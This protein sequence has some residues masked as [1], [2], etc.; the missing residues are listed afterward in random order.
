MLLFA[1]YQ[2]P[3]LKLLCS[4]FMRLYFRSYTIPQLRCIL[5]LE[6]SCDDTGVAVISVDGKVLNEKV[7]SQTNLSVMLG[8]VLPTVARGLHEQEIRSTTNSVL[9]DA[10]IS[11]KDIGSVAVTV[12]P[13]MPL[14]LK[15]GVAYAKELAALHKIPL[16]PVHHM[17]AHALVATLTDPELRFPYLVLLLSGG[18]G[19]LALARGLE[20]FLLLGTALDASPGDV[21]DKLA[22][23]MKLSRLGD[24]RLRYACGGRAIELMAAENVTDSHLFDLPSPRSGDRDCDFSFTGIHLAAERVIK[25]LE[26]E[27]RG[28]PHFVVVPYCPVMLSLIDLIALSSPNHFTFHI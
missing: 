13:G 28:T 5:G 25:R 7:A 15:V 23:R 17:E 10:G 19:L 2:H 3:L 20:D 6:T 11:W 22:R 4:S 14:S 26:T 27:Q 24:D 1:S 18:H 16:I 21:L 9:F 12:K 8:G